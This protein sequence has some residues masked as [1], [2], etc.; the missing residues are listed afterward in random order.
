ML[1]NQIL[2]FSAHRY[3]RLHNRSRLRNAQIYEVLHSCHTGG[4][5]SFTSRNQV[6][7]AELCGLSGTGM[8]NSDQL[9]EGICGRDLIG[10]A[11]SVER[12]ARYCSAPGRQLSFRSRTH[13]RRNAMAALQQLRNE[14][15]AHV[16]GSARNKYVSHTLIHAVITERLRRRI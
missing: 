11:A 2:T 12:V 6:D 1:A 5:N 15:A 14:L 4:L 8:S 16:A 10:I 7:G 3:I 9:D 13:Q